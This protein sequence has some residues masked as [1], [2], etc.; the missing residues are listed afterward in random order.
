MP[1]PRLAQKRWARWLGGILI[2]YALFALTAWRV[3]PFAV[4]RALREAPKALPGFDA[5]IADASFDPF[6]LALTV[7]G[8]AFSHEK[9]GDLAT[10]EEF[11]ASAQPLDL[12]RLAIGLRELR[13]TR[14]RL[15]ATIS[16]EGRSALDYLPRSAP[17]NPP[18]PAKSP[19]IPRL[20]VHHFKITRA[21]LE[22]ESRLPNAPQKISADPIDF[23]LENLSTLPTA[24]GSYSFDARTNHE[25]NLHWSGQ[26]SLRPLRLAGRI[27]LKDIDASRESTAAP[28]LPI[29]IPSGRVDAYTDYELAY[30]E[31]ALSA[32]LAGAH[33]AV[34]DLLWN[35]R[36]STTAPRGPFSIAAGPARLDL[37]VPLPLAPGAKATLSLNSPLAGCGMLSLRAAVAPQPLSGNIDLRVAGLPLAPFSPLTPPP[38]QVTIDSG[39]VSLNARVAISSGGSDISVEASLALDDFSISDRVSRRA[40]AR[41]SRFT[42]DN[43]RASTQAR[44]ASIGRIGLIRPYLRLFR[45][46][47][48]RTNI[49]TAL[50]V[51]LASAAAGGASAA[52]P[53]PA[54]APSR[55]GT[56]WRARLGRFVLS[57]GKIV[58]QDEGVAPAFALAVQAASA[59]LNNLST[60]GRSTATFTSKGFVEK[61]PFLVSGSVRVSS[62][63]AW[64]DAS[65][66]ADGIQ[67]PAFSP[68][69]IKVIGYKLDKGT[70]DLDLAESLAGRR[71]ESANQVILDQLTLGD[72]VDSPGA[73]KVPVKLGIA[74]L[75][76][77]NGVIDLAVP[78]S[79]SLDDPEFRLAP[80]I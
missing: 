71:I 11:Y 36:A 15:I 32:T 6:R 20:V 78:V 8:F 23:A 70:L 19:F 50:G 44:T 12:L 75:K 48:G 31:N 66:K 10:C 52:P 14:P 58:A 17:A 59:E 24:E 13:L 65:V 49:E 51:R 47:D 25:E 4:R 28:G 77:R 22:L 2:I 63:A 55:G 16:S 72:K 74:I 3:V 33:V 35:L 26:L 60:D 56:P 61:A 45:G 43:A 53:P 1:L 79:G 76:D 41:L 54:A 30:S 34:R 29:E 62:A 9:L 40:L 57:G 42:I 46:R 7:R 5:R 73:L 38:T 37:R 69:A 39:A 68:Y 27:I 21:A 18:A 67:L 80:L 64:I